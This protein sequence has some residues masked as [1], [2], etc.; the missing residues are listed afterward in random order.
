MITEFNKYRYLLLEGGRGSGKSSSIARFI[1]YLCDIKK[2][3]VV[4]GRETQNS[5]EESVY[6]ILK[7][8]IGEFSLDWQVLSNEMRHRRTGA[9]IRFKGFREQGAINI[10]GLEGVDVLWVDEAQAISQTT[11]DILIPTIRKEKA[12]VMFS[13]NRHMRDD[14]V[15]NL[16]IGRDDCRHIQ[17][18]YFDNPYCPLN[19]KIE[20]ENMKAKSER[21]YRHIWLGEPLATADD[22]LF[23][24]E[25]LHKA[26]EIEPFGELFG[27]Q[28]VM[29]IDFA[30]Q[31]NDQ[32]VAS[33]L[34]RQTNQHWYLSEQ[35]AWDEAD[36]MVSVGKIVNLIGQYK[37]DV[38]ILDVGGMGHVVYNRLIEVGMDIKRFDGATTQGVD[39]VHYAN[40]R[41]EGYYILKDWFDNMWLKIDKKH[42]DV[43]KELEK[44]KMKFRSDGRRILESKVDMRKH[45]NY[46]PDHADSLMMAVYGAVKFLGKSNAVAS[47]GGNIVRKSVS[48][49]RK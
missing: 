30:A 10:K 38:T 43:V 27:R 48:L 40:A 28:R 21:D 32:C 36:A 16:L 39:V 13:M 1:L 19:L 47:I 41:A 44:I 4:C 29:G 23:N 26:F 25:K 11:L 9:T 45:N 49:R 17:I 22:F 42:Q 46:S 31:G 37:P 24:Y 35:I 3:R 2:V 7:D 12:K 34:D 20:A 6:T 18:N 14:A 15:P 33:I 8:L 5:I